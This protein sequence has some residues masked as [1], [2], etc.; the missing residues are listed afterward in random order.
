MSFGTYQIVCKTT[1]NKYIGSSWCH[2]GIENRWKRHL[3]QLRNGK[4][5]PK[6]Q[7]AWNKYGESDFFFG[8][9]DVLEKDKN[10]CLKREQEYFDSVPHDTLLNTK[11]L[12]SGGNG[13][14]NKG[15]KLGPPSSVTRAKISAANKGN[16]HSPVARAKMSAAKKG[17]PSPNKGMKLGPYGPRL[18]VV[19]P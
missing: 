15:R 5:N 1:G 11:F 9:L 7:N 17:K 18:K 12:A 2:G 8:I 10:S 14:A 16:T 4:H 3:K 19:K 13:S 6:F